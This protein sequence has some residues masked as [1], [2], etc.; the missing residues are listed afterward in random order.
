MPGH[1]FVPRPLDDPARLVAIG[2]TT[3][4]YTHQAV[5]SVKAPLD[6]VAKLI[7]PY[8]GV[9]ASDGAHTRV[10]L[11]MDDFDWLASYLIGLGLDFEVIEPKKMRERMAA[12][13]ERLQRAHQH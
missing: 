8:V 3:A 10:E 13:G 5:V 7:E 12:L 4:H 11:G 6:D 9:L 1:T 2:I